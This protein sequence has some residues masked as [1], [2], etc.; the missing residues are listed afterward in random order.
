MPAPS[1][2][3]TDPRS[4]SNAVRGRVE[5]V[6][7]MRAARLGLAANDGTFGGPDGCRRVMLNCEAEMVV[8]PTP[9]PWE[10]A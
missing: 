6:R 10:V 2:L 9:W 7:W 4:L 8:R 3:T 5:N 1:L